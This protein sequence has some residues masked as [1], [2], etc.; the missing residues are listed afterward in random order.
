[1]PLSLPASTVAV[2]F[3]AIRAPGSVAD[4][5]EYDASAQR[6][7]TLASQQEGFVA[8]RSV[9]DA[10]SGEEI[11]VSYWRDEQ[12]ARAWK[13][14][15]DHLEAQRLGRDRWYA[16]YDV[17]VATVVRSYGHDGA[18]PPAGGPRPAGPTT[19]P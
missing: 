5:A 13:R 2:I 10:A 11:T 1:M 17:V 16:S 18:A 3:S 14:V 4:D 15:S 8:V 7:R 9:Y 6:M 12:A 19:P